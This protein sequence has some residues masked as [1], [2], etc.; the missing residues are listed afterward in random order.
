MCA[1]GGQ[2]TGVSLLA[3]CAVEADAEVIKDEEESVEGD[4]TVSA[5]DA[6]E[7]LPS[8]PGRIGDVL[9]RAS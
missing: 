3:R 9:L 1:G 8:D 4:S 7:R 5:L 2:G 6:S